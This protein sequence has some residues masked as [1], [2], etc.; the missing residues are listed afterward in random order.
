MRKEDGEYISRV[1]KEHCRFHD[2][3]AK[4]MAYLI[5]EPSL[6]SI[7]V[8]VRLTHV[9]GTE[10]DVDLL[11]RVGLVYRDGSV[12]ALTEAA[13]EFVDQYL[14]LAKTRKKLWIWSDRDYLGV[15]PDTD[16]VVSIHD[17]FE[18]AKYLAKL[19]GVERPIVL[20]ASSY[21]KKME[22]KA[23]RKKRHE[24]SSRVSRNSQAQRKRR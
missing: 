7:L 9:Q 2:G 5:S 3:N 1:I 12:F 16:R 24:N 23:R 21:H 19:D 15:N 11:R 8:R 22:T 6:A 10:I 18:G 17:T 4:V 13:E 20:R 14:D